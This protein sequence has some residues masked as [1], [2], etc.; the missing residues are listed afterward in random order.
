MMRLG[1]SI[2]TLAMTVA[3]PA[4][5]QTGDW[6]TVGEFGSDDKSS[7]MMVDAGSLK[8]KP[9]G[10]REITITSYF[11]VARQF[12]S[13]QAYD[14]IHISYRINCAASSFQTFQSVAY[15]QE[16]SI[17]TSDTLTDSRP[18]P[19]GSTVEKIAPA[20]CSGNFSAFTKIGAATPYLEGSAHVW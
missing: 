8:Q 20:V 7:L 14:A 19:P 10:L 2:A 6:R 1:L 11:K 16:Q 12:S 4:M 15:L 17:L 13:G 3:A 5:A 18:Y 9:D